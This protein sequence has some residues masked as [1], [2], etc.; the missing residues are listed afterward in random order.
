MQFRSYAEVLFDSFLRSG[1]QKSLFIHITITQS[2]SYSLNRVF[3]IFNDGK[4]NENIC[5]KQ[6]GFGNVKKPLKRLHAIRPHGT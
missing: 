5:E 4:T 1:V 6:R 2:E 3:L